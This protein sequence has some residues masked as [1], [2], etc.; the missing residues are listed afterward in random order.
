MTSFNTLFNRMFQE[1]SKSVYLIYLIQ[2][3]ASLCF[4]VMMTVSVGG[5]S[6]EIVVGRARET[7]NPI[8]EFLFMFAIMMLMTS[9]VAAFVYWIISSVK[10]ER[11]NRSQTL[12]LIPISDT[13]FLLSNFGTAFITYI[14]LGILEVATSVVTSLPLLLSSKEIKEALQRSHFDFSAQDWGQLLGGLLLIILLGYA[15]Y[16]VVSLINLSSRS[17]MDFLP[18]GSSKALMFLVRLIIIVMIIWLLG[19]AASTLFSVIGQFTPFDFGSSDSGVWLVVL[20]FLAFDVIVTLIDILLLNKF[21][22]A[23]QN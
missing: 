11:I 3:F 7:I 5:H 20:E 19:Y 16:A 21:V 4:T 17:I 9:F 22:E 14:W 12:R 15:W 2:T 13:K 6:Q 23:K 18:S 1:K 10:N 8:V